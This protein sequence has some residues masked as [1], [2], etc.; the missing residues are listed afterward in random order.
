MPRKR[1]KTSA[2]ENTNAPENGNASCFSAHEL[3]CIL[4]EQI[5]K[6]R[7]GVGDVKAINA[8]C[9]ATGK[10]IQSVRLEMD[11]CKLVGATPKS[12]FMKLELKN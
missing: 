8:I 2:D 10:I 4:S 5:Q 11:Y 9:N 3:R 1:T 6:V 12:E 7:N